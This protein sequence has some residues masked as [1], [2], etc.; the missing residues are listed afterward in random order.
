VKILP[1]VVI[2][3]L[4]VGGFF[5][6]QHYSEKLARLEIEKARV[7]TVYQTKVKTLVQVRL[8][9]DSILITDTVIHTDTVRL[10][11]A[12]ERNACNAV[13]QSCEDRVAYRDSIIT[14]LKKK[15]S[16]VK[17]LPWVLGGVVAG[18]VL[19]R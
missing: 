14:V 12:A 9:T 18:F 16:V 10:L 11:L 3:M 13:I 2:G 5:G 1:W 4:V 17:H 8:R 15:P 19:S 7:D 6:R